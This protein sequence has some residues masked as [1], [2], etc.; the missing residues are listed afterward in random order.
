MEKPTVSIK[1]V[2]WSADSV[3]E[4]QTEDAVAN[5]VKTA[6]A[7]NV[8][9]LATGGRHGYGSTLGSPQNGLAIDLSQLKCLDIDKMASTVTIAVG[10]C[11]DVGMVG[12]TLGGGVG[13]FQ[14][15]FGLIIDSL[16]SVRLVTAD[17]GIVEAS[18][19]SNSD[20]FWAIR[21]AGANLGIVTSASYKL[22]KAVND[23]QVMTA[24]MVFP[25]NMKSAYFDA[26]QSIQDKMP[27]ELAINTTIAWDVASGGVAAPSRKAAKFFRDIFTAN[28]RK[29]DAATFSSAFEKFD[30]FYRAHPDAR[31]SV[32]LFESFSNHAVAAVSSDA[33]AYP[34]RD[35]KANLI[36]QMS[37]PDLGNPVEHAANSFARELR[38]G[39]AA[40]SGYPDLAVYV[41]YAKGDE[42]LEQ[43]CGKD[44]L[45][46]LV[47]LKKQ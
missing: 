30:A 15:L 26:L 31:P 42:N 7:A 23:G 11:M 24:D 6:R 35:A 25:A 40:T 8:P 3:A 32:G 9:F 29:L 20:L 13:L 46:R 37:W 27:P 22:H 39:F 17:G 47:A 41:S 44:K 33:T 18:T 1:D 10:S 12:T 36:F 28:V 16:L 19:S 34:W 14:G 43:I 21:R 38:S 45:P 4:P 2:E 5:T